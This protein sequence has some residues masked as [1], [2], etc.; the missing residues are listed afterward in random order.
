MTSVCLSVCNVARWLWS[1]IVQQIVEMGTRQLYLHVKADPN[2][3]ILRSKILLRK[4]SEV[5]NMWSFAHFGGIDPTMS[6]YLSIC[7]AFFSA[8]RWSSINLMMMIHQVWAARA[9][10]QWRGRTRRPRQLA[11]QSSSTHDWHSA[12]FRLGSRLH[13]CSY[14]VFPPTAARTTSHFQHLRTG[15]GKRKGAGSTAARAAFEPTRSSDSCE[16]PS[17]LRSHLWLVLQSVFGR[18]TNGD[19]V[20]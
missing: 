2:R 5:S 1:H 4:H 3:N 11:C 19:C 17:F 9:R 12:L 14:S 13:Y 10:Q 18:H 6:R 8:Q 7:W 16:I 15:S 20:L